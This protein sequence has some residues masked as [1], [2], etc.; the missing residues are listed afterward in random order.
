MRELAQDIL[1]GTNDWEEYKTVEHESNTQKDKIC[2]FTALRRT[3]SENIKT[4]S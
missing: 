1:V 2:K 4:S 3:K